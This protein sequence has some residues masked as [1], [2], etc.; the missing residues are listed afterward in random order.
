LHSQ[1]WLYH[2]QMEAV[3]GFVLAGG[4]SSRMGCDKALLELAGHSLLQ[5]AIGLASSVTK[6][7]RIIGDPAK[8][9]AFGAVIA[10]IYSE[11]GPLAGIHAA[12]AYSSTGL[13]LIL[14]TDLPFVE[15]PFLRYL[16]ATAQ[17]TDAVV[18]V[19]QVGRYFEPLCAV[20]RKQFGE[21]AE[22]AL[23]KGKNKVDALFAEAPTRIVTDQEI[24]GAGFTP[25]MFRNLNAPS[26]LQQAE[27]EFV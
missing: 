16:I 9:A 13:N 21:F 1:A 26:D 10:D 11:R 20:Y 8:Y 5:R 25:A 23:S 3:T 12:L 19:P 6:E 18:I 17:A 14:A 15:G 2:V 22:A 27:Q 4:K 7:V 24:V